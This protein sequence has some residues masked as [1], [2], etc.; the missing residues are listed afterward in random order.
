MKK[1]EVLQAHTFQD[2]YDM[3]LSCLQSTPL[4]YGYEGYH[5]FFNIFH[6]KDIRVFCNFVSFGFFH[7]VT[8]IIVN[9]LFQLSLLEIV[10]FL[11]ELSNSQ[12]RSKRW[13]HQ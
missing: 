3:S 8:T 13:L 2:L 4:H 5:N 6:Y 9:N 10:S 1:G 11:N 12:H 7:S